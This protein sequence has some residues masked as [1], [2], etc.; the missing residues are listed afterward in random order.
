VLKIEKT[1]ESGKHVVYALSGQ[2]SAAHV[3]ELEKLVK[4]ARHEGRQITLD[5]EGVGLV[6][7][8]A[9]RFFSSTA[10]A[11]I[12]L[13]HCPVYVR[14]WMRGESRSGRASR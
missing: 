12:R 3:D 9:V 10:S 8:E 2:I 13:Q 1:S 11:D 7:R 5:L 4:R 14:E 6:E